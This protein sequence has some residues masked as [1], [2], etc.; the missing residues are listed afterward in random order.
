M[1]PF[2]FFLHGEEILF[3]GWEIAPPRVAFLLGIVL[4]AVVLEAARRAVGWLLFFLVL[5]FS[6][7]PLFA[8]HMPGLFYG[9][10]FKFVRVVG[11]NIMGPEGV[12]GLPTRVLGNLFIG[13]MLFGVALTATGAAR[14]FLNLSLSLL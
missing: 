3:R 1:A 8:S 12:I 11:Y 10:S 2:Y 6:I 7:Y 13:F 9:Q 14:F 4:W 5:A